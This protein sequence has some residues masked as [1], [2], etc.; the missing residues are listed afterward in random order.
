M[1]LIYVFVFAYTKS[2]L[3]TT[4]DVVHM[5]KLLTFSANPSFFISYAKQKVLFYSNKMKLTNQT[6]LSMAYMPF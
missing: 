5:E 2:R 1:Q 6:M 4:H 3:K